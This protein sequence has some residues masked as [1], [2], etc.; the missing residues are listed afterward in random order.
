M[1][2]YLQGLNYKKFGLPNMH[3]AARKKYGFHF[4][5]IKICVQELHG[6]LLGCW[7]QRKSHGSSS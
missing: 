6:G 3:V 4:R 2:Q 5:A 7:G 1:T